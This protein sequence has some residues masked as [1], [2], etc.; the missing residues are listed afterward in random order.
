MSKFVVSC[1]STADM[2][3]SYY[4]ER[5]I[6]FVCFHYTMDDV[7]YLDDMGVSMPLDVFYKRIEQGAT[8]TTS[9]VSVGQYV[10]HFEPELKAGRD[11]IHMTLSSGIS[12]T[13]GSCL[14][15]LDDLK[16]KYPE[17]K[18]IV[19]DSLTASVGFGLLVD[20]AADLRD[21]GISVEEAGLIL[22]EK[23]MNVNGWF[24][25]TDLT[26][27]FRGGR[28]SKTSMVVGSLLNICP[29]INIDF[30]GRLIPREKARG[31]K[32]AMEK[33][34]EKMLELADDGAD[35]SGGCFISHSACVADAEKLKEVVE[36][37]FANLRGKIFI[38]DIGTVIGSH[39]GPGT[40]ALFFFGKKRV[41]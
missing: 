32:K 7:E 25:C 41:D 17:R 8:P 2:P 21:Q 10:E 15:A 31:R 33:V 13:Y 5:D 40:V 16:E 14:M 12:G 35:Y 18:I 26:C 9:Q 28:I 27:L 3:R 29:V 34:T 23:R 20:Y 19:I 6:K 22:E 39:T 4:E 11:I 1:C 30:E 24:F 38:N 37:K 36:E